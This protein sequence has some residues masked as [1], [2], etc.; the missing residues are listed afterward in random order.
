MQQQRQHTGW[1]KRFSR[2]E[3][4]ALRAGDYILMVT[5][6]GIGAVAGLATVRDA[7]VQ[8]LG[9]V[10]IALE[11]LDQS[12]TVHMTFGN[13]H[14]PPF[15]RQYSYHDLPPGPDL[16]DLPG[17]APHGIEICNPVPGGESG[18]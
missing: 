9:D 12:Y 6:L 13:L 3:C 17:E 16:A 11:T 2:D 5:I 1:I 10:A 7:V 4:G 18:P 8:D 14:G 15:V